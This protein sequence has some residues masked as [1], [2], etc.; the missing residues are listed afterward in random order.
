MSMVG[1]SGGSLA[2]WKMLGILCFVEGQVGRIETLL[3]LLDFLDVFDWNCAE[4]MLA[5]LIIQMS[6]GGERPAAQ[7]CWLWA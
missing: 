3:F 6:A 5:Q 7:L 4:L 1:C 2:E